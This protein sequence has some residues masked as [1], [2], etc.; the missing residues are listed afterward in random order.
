MPELQVHIGTKRAPL[1]K[2]KFALAI[3]LIR[4]A[5]ALIVAAMPRIVVE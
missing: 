3:V 4:A 1:A 5:A 2:A